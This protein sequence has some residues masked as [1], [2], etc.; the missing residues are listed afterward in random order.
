M[1]LDGL[2]SRCV[3]LWFAAC[4]RPEASCRVK[5][6]AVCSSSGPSRRIMSV[7]FLALDQLH[8]Q[9]DQ[10]TVSPEII[11]TD[12]VGVRQLG[13]R[14]CFLPEPFNRILVGSSSWV[15]WFF[16]ATISVERRLPGAVDDSHATA[17]DQF[18]HFIS[19]DRLAKAEHEIDRVGWR[20]INV[21]GL[22]TVF[23]QRPTELSLDRF[24]LANDARHFGPV[25]PGRVP[26]KR[27]ALFRP[28]PKC[29]L[30]V[31]TARRGCSV[32]RLRL[33]PGR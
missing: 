1:T 9:I 15:E 6:H 33:T 22:S 25:H 27:S 32:D 28:C 31:W 20:R 29:K 30:P 14:P 5:D 18:D 4:E 8:D 26:R 17:T 23:C 3:T 7:S 24:K 21:A 16:K 12:D 13:D 19:V 11:G 2:T 10:V